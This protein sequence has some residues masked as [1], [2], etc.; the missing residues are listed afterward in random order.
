MCVVH[1]C[2]HVRV[3]C[4]G[5]VC[6]CGKGCVVC[7]WEGVCGVGGKGCVCML[8]I[9]QAQSS[10]SLWFSLSPHGYTEI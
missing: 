2:T 10:S 6:V 1:V 9:T 5:C 4:E 8:E 7:V 3:V